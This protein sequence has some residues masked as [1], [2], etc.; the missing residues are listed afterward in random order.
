MCPQGKRV[1]LASLDPPCILRAVSCISAIRKLP[2]V[3]ICRRWLLLQFRQIGS[4][5]SRIP[6]QPRGAHRDRHG[7]RGGDAVDVGALTDE[8][9]IARTSEVVWSWRAHAGAQ[10][11]DDAFRIT[12]ATVA[13]AGSPGRA[14]IS[15]KPLRREGRC[16]S[17]CTC[18]FALSR[19]FF[20]RRPMGACGHPVFPAPSVFEGETRCKPRA[21]RAAGTTGRV[22][23]G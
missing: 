6:P 15:R 1:G 20:A 13:K 18:G 8:R 19:N 7:V 12:R 9:R 16:V 10:V 21:K 2:V 5:L 22:C 14:R 17:A 4:I 23:V 3:P 11:R